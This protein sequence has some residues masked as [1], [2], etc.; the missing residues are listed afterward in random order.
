M[1]IHIFYGF[2]LLFVAWAAYKTGFSQGW[3]EGY[4]NGKQDGLKQGK[5]EG[6][7]AGLKASVK[8]HMI[9]KMTTG[10]GLPGVQEELQQQVREELL[11]AINAPPPAKPKPPPPK[12]QWLAD[13]G[14]TIW[15][16]YDGWIVL[17]GFAVLLVYLF[18]SG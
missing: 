16:R 11:K 12:T 7:K 9:S 10:P 6:F 13:L 3:S 18:R 2:I 1:A 17:I 8:E 5:E 14:R 4:G 15:E